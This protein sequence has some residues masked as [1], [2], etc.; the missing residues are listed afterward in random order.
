MSPITFAAMAGFIFVS[1]HPYSD[2]NGRTRDFI[3][4]FIL[5]SFRYP[6]K[7]VTYR[8][9][10]DAFFRKSAD[11]D[12]NNFL[13]VEYDPSLLSRSINLFCDYMLSVTALFEEN[14]RAEVSFNNQV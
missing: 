9:R 3:E 13:S 11:L 12:G 6:I 4:D 10:D 1:I 7:Q 2:G 8:L 14:Y 5:Q